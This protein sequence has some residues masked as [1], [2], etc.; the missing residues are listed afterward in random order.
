MTNATVVSVCGD[1]GGAS[2]LAPVIKVLKSERRVR[3]VVY[4]YNEGIEVMRRC[5]VSSVSLPNP[6]DADW[7]S[8]RLA[9]DRASLVLTGTSHN[10][11]D[12]EKLFISSSHSAGVPSISV[13]DF[14]SN[15]ALRFGDDCGGLTYIPD[16]IAVMDERARDE[17][18][19]GGFSGKNIV[20]TGQPA[21]D[22]LAE[23]RRQFSAARR[24]ATRAAL[25]LTADDLL[26][27]FVSQ[28]LRRLSGECNDD[29]RFLGFDEESV[30]SSV[31][32]SLGT[33]S[34]KTDRCITL[35]I[36]P[37]PRDRTAWSRDDG[38][39]GVKVLVSTSGDG[40]DDVMASDLVVGMNSILLVE[41][42]YLGGIVLSVQPELR[43]VDTLPTNRSG[44]SVGVYREEDIG[45]AIESLLLDAEVRCAA[46]AR[47][48]CLPRS[49]GAARR[50]V[51]HVYAWL[52]SSAS[53][54]VS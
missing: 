50:V 33:T 20:V 5:N 48:A 29:P 54:P 38:A 32:T 52:F 40:R 41:A 36:R 3:L 2:A 30:L 53:C 7:D 17:M 21:F 16:M 46:A 4:A 15:Y 42:C 43:R 47:T 35:L 45:P 8:R 37:H 14:W 9:E 51:N 13:L 24:S 19:A 1:P 31:I 12:W 39:P 26:V 22:A 10:G 18:I 27:V 25:G 23:C 11:L 44:A 34:G 6:I 28:P 49:G